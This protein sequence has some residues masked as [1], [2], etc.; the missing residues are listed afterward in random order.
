MGSQFPP[1]RQKPRILIVEDE[2]LIADLIREIVEE[3]GCE[4]IGPFGTLVEAL[5]A[6]R[7]A[8]ADAAIVDLVLHGEQAYP[9]ADVLSRRGIPFGFATGKGT[10]AIE[11]A[12]EQRPFL[13]KPFAAEEVRE[14]INGL[15]KRL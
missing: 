3:C 5:H 8:N 7:S 15:L 12:W 13:G 6:C 14:L 2:F 9:I 1:K 10:A 11:S 4:V